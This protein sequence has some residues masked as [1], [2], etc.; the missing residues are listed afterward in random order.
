MSSPVSDPAGPAVTL[1]SA[2]YQPHPN[3]RFLG[4]IGADDHFI[5]V[6]L[7]LDSRSETHRH[8][9]LAAGFEGL[10]VR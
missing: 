8:F 1:K 10:D 6:I 5:D 9:V 3:R 4:I 2:G 7:L